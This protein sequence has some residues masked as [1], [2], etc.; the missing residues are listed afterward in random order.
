MSIINSFL[1]FLMQKLPELNQELEVN[2]D[3]YFPLGFDNE[4]NLNIYLIYDYTEFV[5]NHFMPYTEE[6]EAYGILANLIA[7]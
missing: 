6:K 3:A 1:D 2:P 5:I 4:I 7:L